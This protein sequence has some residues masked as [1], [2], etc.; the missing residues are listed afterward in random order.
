MGFQ[1]RIP[2]ASRGIVGAVLKY[3]EGR[4]LLLSIEAK[5]ALRQSASALLLAVVCGVAVLAAWLLLVTALIGG[6]T[7]FLGWSWVLA[8]AVTGGVH[9]LLIAALVL[10]IRRRLKQSTW[11]AE[12]LKQ[13]EKDRACLKNPTVT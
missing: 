8:M 9:L 7:G 4:G 10:L 12:T 5:Q 2:A 1:P 13:L 11:F 3:L 6:L